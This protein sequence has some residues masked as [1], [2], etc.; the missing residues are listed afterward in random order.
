MYIHM[1]KSYFLDGSRP[2]WFKRAQH[3]CLY[4]VYVRLCKKCVVRCMPALLF[5]NRA[6]AVAV[7]M[8]IAVAVAISAMAVAAAAV[9]HPPVINQRE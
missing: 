4:Y 8:A 2:L 1:S 7:A 9:P 3:S 5:F 6:A